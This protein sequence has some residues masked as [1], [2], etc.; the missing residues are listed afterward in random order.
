MKIKAIR[1]QKE[2][3][4]RIEIKEN[5][6]EQYRIVQLSRVQ[7][8]KTR[9][10]SE[11]NSLVMDTAMLRQA[12]TEQLSISSAKK[13]DLLKL[14]RSGVIPTKYYNFY[15]SLK[16]ASTIVDRLP[17]PDCTETDAE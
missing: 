12:Y 2:Y 7:T 17:E 5:Y 13:Q 16:T 14:C 8:R 15:D 6:D 1:V 11:A 10:S 9:K 4:D 3:P